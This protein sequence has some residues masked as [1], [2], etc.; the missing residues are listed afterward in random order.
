M[1]ISEKR[2]SATNSRQ[3]VI[4]CAARV[5]GNENPIEVFSENVHLSK[6]GRGR[7]SNF[8]G[9]RLPGIK[10]LTHRRN[11][12]VAWLELGED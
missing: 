4:A 10:R 7:R 8:E 9:R 12:I 5:S 2:V 3:K 6:K 1:G 11:S